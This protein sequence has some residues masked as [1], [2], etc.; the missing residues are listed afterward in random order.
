MSMERQVEI[1]RMSSRSSTRTAIN[2]YV[3]DVCAPRYDRVHSIPDYAGM[4]LR[5]VRQFIMEQK[6]LLTSDSATAEQFADIYVDEAGTNSWLQS[7]RS[8]I[9]STSSNSTDKLVSRSETNKPPPTKKT[10]DK[11]WHN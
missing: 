2:T 7:M 4:E 11:G 6:S 5:L 10:K 9:M 3:N 8:S 1:S